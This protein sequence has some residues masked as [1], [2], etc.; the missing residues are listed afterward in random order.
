MRLKRLLILVSALIPFLLTGCSLLESDKSEKF[1]Y[2]QK[3][4]ILLKQE[5]ME[6]HSYAH[7]PEF[8]K[9]EGLFLSADRVTLGN[10]QKLPDFFDQKI[11]IVDHT[12][13]LKDTAEKIS[14]IANIPIDVPKSLILPDQ[15]DTET[16]DPIQKECQISYDG[17]LK[18]LL[19]YVSRYYETDWEYDVET[20]EIVF[21]LFKTKTYTIS[22]STEALQLSSSISNQSSSDSTGGES[23]VSIEGAQKTTSEANI[24]IFDDIKDN[25]QAIAPLGI[26]IVNKSAGTITVKASPDK[27][28]IVDQYIAQLN[29]KLSR[30]AVIAVKVYSLELSSDNQ[31]GFDLNMIF[32]SFAKDLNL[33]MSGATP[34]D[35]SSGAGNLT[36]AILETDQATKTAYKHLAGSD[37]I[38]KALESYGDVSLVTSGSGITMNNQPLPIQIVQRTG[39]LK[40]TAIPDMENAVIAELTPGSVTTGFSMLATPHIID[41]SQVILRYNLS[42]SALEEMKTIQSGEQSIQTPE[43]STRSFMQTAKMKL[44]STLLMAGFEENRD[45][46]KK[47]QGLTGFS[48]LGNHKKSVFVISITVNR[49]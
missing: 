12:N 30:Q 14:S 31:T 18:G 21:F 2:A 29:E 5:H 28:K 24:S 33:T 42:L 45:E 27:L 34:F 25:I 6:K 48:R 8:V 36:A 47:G 16:S 38:L 39:Y 32:N 19:D 9:K 20:G 37:M 1:V 4:D 22:A 44:G 11:S 10:R 3:Q 17:T 49:V 46:F 26:V 35:I 13:S 41:V 40:S 15:S 7:R 23:D 43:T